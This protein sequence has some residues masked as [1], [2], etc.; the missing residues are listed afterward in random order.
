MADFDAVIV[1]AGH[2]GLVCAAYLAKAG[3]KVCVV[4][5]RNVVGGAAVT[6]ELWPGF[7]L[8]VAAYWMSLM[9]PKVMIDLELLKYGVKVVETAPGIQ[10]F[11]DGSSVTF[12]PDEK[13]MCDE[14]RKYSEADA[15]AYPQFVAHMKKLVVHLRKMLYEVPVDITSRKTKDLAK[16]AGMVWRNRA[17]GPAFYDV[18]DLLTLSCHDYL[19]R[20]FS[21]PEVLTVF[22]CYASGSGGNIG[23]MSP[24]SAYV[25]AR[26]Y[27]RESDTDAGPGG[28]VQGGM[29]AISNALK[30]VCLD[31]G[32]DIR[33]NTPVSEIVVVDG[34]ARGVKL[35]S[36]EM[37]KARAVISNA[38]AKTLFL[39]LIKPEYLPGDVIDAV[40]RIR[41]T[42]SCFK[43][44]MALSGLPEWSALKGK[45][46]NQVPGSITIAENLEELQRAFESAQHGEMA[47]NPYMWILTPSAFDK[48]AAPAGMHTMS[49]LGGH[50]PYE[51]KDGRPWD[52]TTKEE[53]FE[54]VANQIERYAP[55]FKQLVMHKQVLVAKD[56]EQMFDLPTGH[57]HHGELSLDQIFFRRP[58]AH[59]ADY[60]TP[61]KGLYQCGA[62]AHPGGGVTGVPG[63]NA[64]HV[65]LSDLK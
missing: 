31:N 60:R 7:H 3:H 34:T 33:C 47:K 63:H 29:G 43:I 11:R 27:L 38:N 36:G 20:W 58:I 32:V 23:P 56:L 46:I 45:N 62:S 25:L 5:R 30:Q 41:T 40:K 59:Y 64:A 48:T 21:S 28:L 9:Q 50:V 1:G 51:L 39:R 16:A 65:I 49:L 6:E 18:W 61:I 22:G 10:P 8:S 24:G 4:E 19:K 26:P 17:M 54:I 14:L 2:N 53:L 37:I 44:N 15:Q 42:S 57:V 12:W 13:R 52:D 35:A 55:G